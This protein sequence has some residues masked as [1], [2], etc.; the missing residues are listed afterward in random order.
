MVKLNIKIFASDVQRRPEGS[1]Q[2]DCPL[3]PEPVRVL[4]LVYRRGGEIWQTR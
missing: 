3:R 1:A 4:V 2:R